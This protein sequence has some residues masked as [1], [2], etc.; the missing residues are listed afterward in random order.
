MSYEL[1]I[2]IPAFNEA[3]RIVPTL[4]KICA[5]LSASR[6]TAETIV[7]NDGSTDDTSESVRLQISRFESITALR[8]LENP[9]HRGK[10]YSVR[11][12]VLKSTGAEVLFTD[13]DLSSPIEEY[14]KLAEPIRR[15]VAAIAFGSRAL[16]E[17]RLGQRE[18]PVRE[19]FGRTFNLFV[20]GLAGLPFK[21]TQCGFKLFTRKAADAVF[22]LQTVDGFGF[23]VEILYIARKLGFRMVEV[24]VVWSHDERTRIHVL[25]DGIRMGLDVL[26]VRLQDFSGKYNHLGGTSTNDQAGC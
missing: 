7:V 23:D 2:V 22:P 16:K 25:R 15:G 24:P 26:K 20:R 18:S 21:D 3:S 8:L 10:G 12:G 11:H 14:G 9:G 6:M 19:F 1:S 13:S 5:F 4:D 17:S